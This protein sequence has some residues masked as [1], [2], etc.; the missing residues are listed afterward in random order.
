M[1]P[2]SVSTS[3][4]SP[5]DPPTIESSFESFESFSV[6]IL[7]FDREDVSGDKDRDDDNGW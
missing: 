6:N 5:L 2:G 7:Y 4:S 1:R 3:D